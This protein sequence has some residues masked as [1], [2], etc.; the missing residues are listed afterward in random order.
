LIFWFIAQLAFIKLSDSSAFFVS[1][2]LISSLT[3]R[4]YETGPFIIIH[5]MFIQVTSIYVVFLHH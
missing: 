2:S 1:V 3:H 4:L 5:G